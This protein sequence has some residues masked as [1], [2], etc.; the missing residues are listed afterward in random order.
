MLKWTYSTPR[1]SEKSHWWGFEDSAAYYKNYIYLADNGG[2]MFCMDIN[3]MELVWAQDV[4][5]DTNASPVLEITENDEKFLYVA[6]S[7]HW[8][9][10]KSTWT[11]NISIYKINAMTGE[12]VWEKP[13][14]AHTENVN[15]KDHVSGG[16]QATP[17]VGKG[18]I[19]DLVIYPVAR[20]PYKRKGL[21]VALDKHTGGERWVWN[22]PHY[23][24]SSPVCIYT[25]EGGALVVQCDSKGYMHL[26]DGRTGKIL[27]SINLGSNIEASPAVFENKIVVGTRGRK[28][29]GVT[30]R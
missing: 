27:D 1:T 22:M 18:P 12:I 11:G 2:N 29:V 6:P 25:K 7:L 4:K 30:V 10:D 20:T 16:V 19:D 17:V 21:L 9:M 3:T 5:D 8:E 15:T 13:Y 23:A 26:L 28:I 14:M 24:W